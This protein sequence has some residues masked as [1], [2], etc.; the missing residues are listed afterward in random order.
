MAPTQ[1]LLMFG[2]YQKLY[3]QFVVPW[4]YSILFRARDGLKRRSRVT[5]QPCCI[6]LFT[7]TV[8]HKV[9]TV[10]NACVAIFPGGS[11]SAETGP[12]R[13]GGSLGL[14]VAAASPCRRC[15]PTL[16]HEQL[17]LSQVHTGGRNID[18]QLP[19]RTCRTCPRAQTGP[20]DVV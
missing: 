19:L 7:R 15:V 3:V 8:S 9:G 5:C 18:Q 2:P 20:A 1:V 14:T 10:L 6:V 12:K 13:C 16:W 4:A 11:K 17:Q